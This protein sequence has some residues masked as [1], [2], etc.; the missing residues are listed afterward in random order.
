MVNPKA[1]K[2]AEQKSERKA[3]VN[4]MSEIVFEKERRLKCLVC[5]F[6]R[7]IITMF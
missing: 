2:T 5:Y 4:G 6:R 1:A 7:A 3:S